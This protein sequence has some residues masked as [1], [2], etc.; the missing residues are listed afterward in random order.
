[1]CIDPKQLNKA[2][3][4]NNYQL[5]VIDDILPEISSARVFSKLDLTSAF[6]QL[7]LDDESSKLTCFNTPFGRFR[8]RRLP[9][10]LSVSSEIFQHRLNAALEGLPGVI[11]VADDITQCMVYGKGSDDNAA[12]I[13]HDAKLTRLL[14]RCSA[15]NIKLNR[16]KSVFRTTDIPFLGHRITKHGLG[17]DPQKVEAVLN[18]PVPED[19]Q[20][21][22]RLVGFVNYLSRYLPSLSHVLEPLRQLTRPEVPWHWTHA[23]Q[24]AMD[25]VKHLVTAAPVL[26]YYN[27]ECE[28]SIQCDASGKGLGV[29]LL[30]QGRPIAYASRALTD[31][32]TRY[33]SIEREMLAVVFALERFHQYTFVRHT[34]V[35]SD[36]KPWK[37]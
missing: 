6:W 31:T 7:N 8:W 34:K 10:G 19:V 14:E 35:I 30:Q 37:S 1:M 11:C 32:E 12:L 29:A 36:H 27:L 13:D 20:D 17:P 21:I 25:Q 16:S 24:E 33:A 9:F 26:A 2:L 4:R 23:Q 5:P 28:L 22:Q 18:M 3:K 15:L